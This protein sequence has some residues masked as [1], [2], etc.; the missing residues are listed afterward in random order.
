MA[1]KT[2]N[3]NSREYT[4]LELKRIK[5]LQKKTK[6]ELINI[7]FDTDNK[8]KEALQESKTFGD[9]NTHLSKELKTYKDLCSRYKEDSIKLGEEV[10]KLNGICRDKDKQINTIKENYPG[11]DKLKQAEDHILEL[12]GNINELKDSLD[13]AAT[14][15]F[16]FKQEN[17][18]L[19]KQLDVSLGLNAVI[20]LG[21]LICWFIF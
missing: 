1:T 13:D 15:S 18:K 12:N 16:T 6:A 5:G 21:F 11:Y 14:E 3:E 9:N 2:A 10:R 7:I 17:N 8:C 19:R 20:A 4:D